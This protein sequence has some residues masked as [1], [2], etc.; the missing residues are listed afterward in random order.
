MITLTKDKLKVY[1][2]G[3]NNDVKYIKS[4]LTL[5]EDAD[6]VRQRKRFN[7]YYDGK[8]KFWYKDKDQQFFYFGHLDFVLGKLSESG[9]ET[10]LVNFGSPVFNFAISEKLRDYQKEAVQAF[11]YS[12]NIG[13]IIKI[14]TRGGKTITSAECIKIFISNF[15]KAKCLFL[16]DSVDLL[17]QTQKEFSEFLGG[18]E[19]GLIGDSKYNPLQITIATIQTIQIHL[20]PKIDKRFAKKPLIE[21]QAKKKEQK[22]KKEYTIKWLKSIDFLIVDEVHEFTSKERMSTIRKMENVVK[23]LSLSATPFK[24]DE[25]QQFKIIGLTGGIINEVKKQRLEKQGVLAKSNVLLILNER[26]YGNSYL[27]A[28]KNQINCDFRN[29]AIINLIEILERLK[30]K[31][32]FLFS[33][34]KHGIL[35]SEKTGIDFISGYSKK[36]ERNLVK[37]KFTQSKDSDFI[38]LASD[39]Y[40]KGITITEARVFI[41]P[42]SVK[43]STLLIQKFGR[44]IGAMEN[45]STCLI[46]D[47]IDFSDYFSS[48]SLNRIDVYEK[49]IGKNNIHSLELRDENFSEKFESIV[50]KCLEMN[51]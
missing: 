20:F 4:E 8:V 16:V 38:L 11:F 3:D 23:M 14:P 35:I 34:V 19:I 41:N 27:D 12:S 28:V 13:G 29:E 9:V 18:V 25:I 5:K 26:S 24:D 32:L 21:K 6:V 39:I 33:S 40:K 42:N 44:I 37:D 50:K 46:I 7:Q 1:F 22:Q 48:H 17:Y 15:K 2:S 43:E 49:E 51:L 10:G 45:K 47:I 36:E 31:T 30:Q